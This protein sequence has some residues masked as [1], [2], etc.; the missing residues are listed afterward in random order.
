MF[1]FHYLLPPSGKKNKILNFTP[2]GIIETLVWDFNRKKEKILKIGT[3]N[4]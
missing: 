2:G 4:E 1:G 3:K